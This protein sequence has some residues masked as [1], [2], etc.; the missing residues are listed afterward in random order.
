MTQGPT[1]PT[2]TEAGAV[3]LLNHAK[4]Y[5]AAKQLS[6]RPLE[7][8]DVAAITSRAIGLAAQRHLLLPDEEVLIERAV[9]ALLGGHLILEGPPGTGKTT[10]ARILATA[11]GC[12][13]TTVTATADWSSYDVVGGLQPKLIGPESAAT[14]VI[15]PHLGHVSQAAVACADAIALHEADPHQYPNQAHW[16]L[17]DELNRA[18]IDK[19]IGPLYTTLSGGG[20]R[21]LPLWFGDV[22]ERQEVWIPD[23]FRIIGTINSVDTSYVFR[24]S[25]G[26]TRRFQ[27]V[28]VGVPEASQLDAELTQAAIQAAEW[29][30]VTYGGTNSADEAALDQAAND[31][32]N[33]GR[34]KQAMQLLESIVRFVRYDDPEKKRLG[35]PIGTAQLVDV[36]RQIAIRSPSAATDTA[37]LVPAIDRGIADRMIPQMDNLLRD[38]L[39]ALAAQLGD[40]EF[41]PLE[42]TRRALETLR[43]AQTTTFA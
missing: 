25:Q 21:R 8:G 15:A 37:A 19:A 9:V 23:R 35:W 14:E 34:V 4:D 16:L 22:P 31:F 11:F 39:D 28:Y 12:D 38:Q 2:A 32:L 29:H 20:E 7:S 5:R 36:M 27:F 17:L 24:L 26:L 33:D 40:A 30:A 1:L 42:R 41:A 10:L 18:E 6:G 3:M 43:R 13:I